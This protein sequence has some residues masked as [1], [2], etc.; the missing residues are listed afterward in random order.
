MADVTRPTMDM[1]FGDTAVR[2]ACGILGAFPED[3]TV[4]CSKSAATT[5]Q[6]I[7][8]KYRCKVVL[9]PPEMLSTRDAWAVTVARDYVWSPGL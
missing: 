5:A 9:V 2:V 6:E 1:D 8:D 4:I 3:V 7:R